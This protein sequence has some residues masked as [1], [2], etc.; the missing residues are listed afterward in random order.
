MFIFAN[1]IIYTL[2]EAVGSTWDT[3]DLLRYGA[4]HKSL[5]VDGDWWRLISNT[6]L[7]VGPI[8]LVMNLVSILIF[9][10]I[11]ERL[12]GTLRFAWLYILTGLIGAAVALMFTPDKIVA[13]ASGSV[14]GLL[15]AGLAWVM[16]EKNNL[17]I[18]YVTRT[19]KFLMAIIFMN[20]IVGFL[21]EFICNSAHI[22]GLL[23]GMLVMTSVHKAGALGLKRLRKTIEVVLLI[24]CMVVIGASVYGVMGSMKRPVESLLPCTTE[25]VDQYY[26]DYYKKMYNRYLAT[27]PIPPMYFLSS[28][29]KSKFHPLVYGKLFKGA[30]ANISLKHGIH[31]IPKEYYRFLPKDAAGWAQ[32]LSVNINPRMTPHPIPTKGNTCSVMNKPPSNTKKKDKFIILEGRR[33]TRKGVI[34]IK[35]I[36]FDKKRI[37]SYARILSHMLDRTTIKYWGPVEKES[38]PKIVRQHYHK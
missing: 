15:G 12:V 6:F 25:V 29:Y 16:L 32:Y 13:G 3:I 5:V 24:S 1:L 18:Q 11:L 26:Y 14:F 23:G 20:V 31:R 33:L 28:K 8:H 2:V 19:K 9:G 30:E 36:V 21:I 35:I 22:G 10:A 7:H 17:P 27:T 37:Q 34:R 4:L 38:V